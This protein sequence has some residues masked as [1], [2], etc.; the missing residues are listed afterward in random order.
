[1]T[2]SVV[3]LQIPAQARYLVLARL[4]LSGVA[5]TTPKLDAEVLADLKLAVTEACSNAVRHAYPDGVGVVHVRF[6]LG[7]DEL[8]I[9]VRDRGG[10]FDP[11]DVRERHEAALHE[12]GMGLA[13][14]RS[15]TDELA[16]QAGA[17]GVGTTV[18]FTKRLP[19]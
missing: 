6:E 4:G 2:T 1:M 5:Q 3:E 14:I 15:V 8:A 17:D 11:T 7:V 9:E 12:Q 10:G 16:V 18:R 19:G 13:I